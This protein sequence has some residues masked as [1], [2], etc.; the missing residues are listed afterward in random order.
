MI[1]PEAPTPDDELERLIEHQALL[2]HTVETPAE[3]KSAWLELQRLHG[4]RSPQRVAEME[5][6]RGLS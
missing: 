6:D 1:N 3:R 2:L 4:L 5:S